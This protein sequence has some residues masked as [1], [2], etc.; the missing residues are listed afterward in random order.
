MSGQTEYE[1][2]VTV[3]EKS[4]P[5]VVAAMQLLASYGAIVTTVQDRYV[6]LPDLREYAK[7][8]GYRKPNQKADFMWG[9]LVRNDGPFALHSVPFVVVERSTLLPRSEFLAG[10]DEDRKSACHSDQWLIS[11]NSLKTWVGA[12]VRKAPEHFALQ[13]Q[14]LL[15]SWVKQL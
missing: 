12:F 7:A 14:T 4:P 1:I 2:H 8:K 5:D 6:G 13:P 11:V 10:I 9:V 15:A 3:P